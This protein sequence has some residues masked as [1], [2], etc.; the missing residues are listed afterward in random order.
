[1]DKITALLLIC[2]Y[3]AFGRVSAQ[4]NIVD[5]VDRD[6]DTVK[7]IDKAGVHLLSLSSSGEIAGSEE[8]TRSSFIHMVHQL[9]RSNQNQTLWEIK[10]GV[11]DCPL[12]VEAKFL[13]E[14]RFTDFNNDGVK[15]VWIIYQTA[16]KGDISPST[17]IVKLMDERGT[18]YTLEAVQLITYPD[19]TIEGGD[20]SFD[21]KFMEKSNTYRDYA[22][23]FLK[24][25]YSEKIE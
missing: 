11:E 18:P 14:P 23:A 12:D 15:E 3:T 2:F 10:D 13:A 1:M 17:I 24:E 20:Y 25:F 21:S 6:I 4:H 16:C 9:I 7:Y 5:F 22:F 19:G 8:G